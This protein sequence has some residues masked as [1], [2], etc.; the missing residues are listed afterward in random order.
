[1]KIDS[2]LNLAFCQPVK[3]TIR[4][5]CLGRRQLV[6]VMGKIHDTGEALTGKNIQTDRRLICYFYRRGRHSSLL[7]LLRRLSTCENR[8]MAKR[9][10]FLIS[11]HKIT[12]TI[13]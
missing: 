5:K 3:D 11:M 8:T 9:I 12:S 7:Q 6:R 13:V 10:R 1:M 4:S 2:T